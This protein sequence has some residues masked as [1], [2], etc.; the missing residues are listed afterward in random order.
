MGRARQSITSTKIPGENQ[1]IASSFTRRPV[2][3]IPRPSQ[4]VI[5]IR[6]RPPP[7]AIWCHG[8]QQGLTSTSHRIWDVVVAPRGASFKQT[9]CAWSQSGDR[10]LQTETCLSRRR[11][12]TR[13][14]RDDERWTASCK[15]KEELLRQGT[16]FC[17]ETT[18][19]RRLT[20][21]SK[22]S[23]SCTWESFVWRVACPT[24]RGRGHR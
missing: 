8:S 1:S 21:S 10:T 24:E 17:V 14:E 5:T 7:R 13:A 22:D 15:R 19:T 9:G 20:D 2:F 4:F 11:G 3:V 16:N 12:N 18:E 23:W 6:T